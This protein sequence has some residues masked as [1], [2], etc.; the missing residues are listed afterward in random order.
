MVQTNINFKVCKVLAP[1]Y[2]ESAPQ[3]YQT[4][5]FTKIITTSIFYKLLT[6]RHN[7]AARILNSKTYRGKY[8]KFEVKKY[9]LILPFKILKEN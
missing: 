7:K 3:L 4:P 6:Q 5:Y 1:H 8:S 9:F 2:F